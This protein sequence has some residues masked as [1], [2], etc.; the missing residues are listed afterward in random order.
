MPLNKL[1]QE[2]IIKEKLEESGLKVRPE[3]GKGEKIMKDET[4][5]FKMN[6]QDKEIFR[7][8]AESKGSSISN[9]TRRLIYDFFE[10]QGL[11]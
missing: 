4:I 1:E 6:A 7:R 5:V 8:Y 9:E 3:S 11:K 10:K 2:K